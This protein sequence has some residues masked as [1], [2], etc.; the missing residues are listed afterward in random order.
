MCYHLTPSFAEDNSPSESLAITDYSNGHTPKFDKITISHIAIFIQFP[1]SLGLYVS[2]KKTW[3]RRW[4]ANE[5]QAMTKGHALN[6]PQSS[7]G[8]R[9][10]KTGAHVKAGLCKNCTRSSFPGP[11]H[12]FR[13][14]GANAALPVCQTILAGRFGDRVFTSAPFVVTPWSFMTGNYSIKRHAVALGNP[15]MDGNECKTIDK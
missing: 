4:F 11:N 1:F 14:K 12:H 7:V 2:Q 5:F 6:I 9:M 13:Q 10:V 3:W 8:K 15:H